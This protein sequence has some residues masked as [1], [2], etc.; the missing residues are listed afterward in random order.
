MG[1]YDSFTLAV[2]IAPGCLAISFSI[3]SDFDTHFLAFP[4]GILWSLQRLAMSGV[5]FSV[6]LLDCSVFLHSLLIKLGAIFIFVDLER[7]LTDSTFISGNKV[8]QSS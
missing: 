5:I 6:L 3:A 2:T 4:R 1:I 8:E 7:G